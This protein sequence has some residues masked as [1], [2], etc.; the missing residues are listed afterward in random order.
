V[1][2][3]QFRSN[4]CQ[5]WPSQVEVHIKSRLGQSQVRSGYVQ[6]IQGQ[7]MVKSRSAHGQVRLGRSSSC[8]VMS[9]QAQVKV[10]SKSSLVK[11]RSDQARSDQVKSGHIWSV[12][13]MSFQS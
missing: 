1:K 13:Y 5:A 10:M 3:V 6:S 2:A 12:Q 8:P 4:S 7:V 11:V 9:C